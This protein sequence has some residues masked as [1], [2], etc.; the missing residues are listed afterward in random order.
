VFTG[1]DCS[2]KT[3]DELVSEKRQMKAQR[4]LTALVI[5]VTIGVAVHAAT[6]GSSILPFFLLILLFRV[7]SSASRNSQN[8]LIGQAELRHRKAVQ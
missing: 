8:L 4:I 6:H 2:T 7:G 3:L 1:E 5:G